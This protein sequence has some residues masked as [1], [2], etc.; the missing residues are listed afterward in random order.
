MEKRYKIAVLVGSLLEK[1]RCL[2]GSSTNVQLTCRYPTS[3]CVDTNLLKSLPRKACS[4]DTHAVPYEPYA[5]SIFFQEIDEVGNQKLTYLVE[6]VE[7]RLLYAVQHS[8]G[9][10][11][12]RLENG[13]SRIGNCVL[14]K[15]RGNRWLPKSAFYLL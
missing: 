12:W 6:K 14:R 13:T 2:K 5:S 3:Y 11:Q 10:S 7:K 1:S 4:K 9:L 8:R 15:W